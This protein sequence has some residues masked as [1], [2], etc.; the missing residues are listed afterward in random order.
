[1]LKSK[2]TKAKTV[3]LNGLRMLFLEL[4]TRKIDNFAKIISCLSGYVVVYNQL[5]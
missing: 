5:P 3:P 4:V 2:E 1:M